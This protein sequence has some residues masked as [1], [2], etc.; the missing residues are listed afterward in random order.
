[1][2][3]EFIEKRCKSL[4][5]MYRYFGPGSEW[6]GTCFPVL[7]IINQMSQM[8]RE[9]I[10]NTLEDK[11]FQHVQILSAEI[12]ERPIGSP[13]NQRAAAY[14]D[15]Y[16]RH[17][18][19][20]VEDQ[21]Y[22]CTAWKHTSTILEREGIE[23]QA[24]ANAF[25][26]PCDVSGQVVHAGTLSELETIAAK[27]KILF[28]YGDLVRAPLSP[29]SWFLLDDRDRSV[30]ELLESLEPAALCAPP[31]ATDY[32]GQLTEDAELDLPAVT[33]PQR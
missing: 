3:G 29:K 18:G 23:L 32:F 17:S 27:G 31:T 30:I 19:L 4:Y 13:G 15:A 33:S 20:E 11:L 12:G 7:P 10:L 9:S 22:P 8:I 1:M 14:I 24:A 26:L 16:F 5:N 6:R 28:L 25:S 21:P 2:D